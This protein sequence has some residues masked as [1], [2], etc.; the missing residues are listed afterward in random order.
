MFAKRLPQHF[1]RMSWRSRYRWLCAHQYVVGPKCHER[2]TH[3]FAS[4]PDISPK[5]WKYRWC[6]FHILLLVRHLWGTKPPFKLFS[7]PSGLL[8]Y[9]FSKQTPPKTQRLISSN[10]YKLSTHF[11]YSPIFSLAQLISL[12][13]TVLSSWNQRQCSNQDAQGILTDTTVDGSEIR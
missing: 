10:C 7:I 1:E 3:S 6:E 12:N 5:A 13:Q 2:L 8:R 4:L 11:K 9:K